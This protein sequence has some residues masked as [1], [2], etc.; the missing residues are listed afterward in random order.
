MLYLIVCILL[1][2]GIVMQVREAMSKKPEFL[3]PTASLKE[4]ALKMRELDCG[5]M[6]IGENDKLIG[7]VTDRDIVIRTL[8][9]GRDPNNAT[10]RDIMSEHIEY[11]FEE[12]DLNKAV[13]HMEDKQIHRLV[14]LNKNKRM[15]GIL[16]LGDIARQS[17]NGA[18]C[19]EAVER[20]LENK[21]RTH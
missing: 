17:N 14:V 15:T 1:K 8:A 2:E 10:L 9:K 12:D 6:P 4:A 13:Q 21:E 19:A 11:C 7:T 3:P 20:I 18:L 5:F 16:S